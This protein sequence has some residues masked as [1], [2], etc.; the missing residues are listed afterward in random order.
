VPGLADIV[1]EFHKELTENQTLLLMEFVLH[2][3]AEHSQLSKNVWNDGFTFSDMLG[4]LFQSSF[5]DDDE[6]LEDDDFR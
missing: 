4:S 6:D 2:G 3:L 5:E 1:N